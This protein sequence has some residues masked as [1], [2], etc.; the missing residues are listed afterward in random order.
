MRE[1]PG[2][3]S[4]PLQTRYRKYA[5]DGRDDAPGFNTPSKKIEIYSEVLL[6]HG[7]AAL[8]E[9][10]EPG[11]G[12]AGRPNLAEDFP[13]ILTSVKSPQYLGSQGRAFPA[14]RRIK[15]EPQI[16]LHPDAAEARGIQNG[17]WVAL[18]TPHGRLR[19]K[20][21]YSAKLHPKVVVA[22]HG[23]WQANTTLSL[24]GYDVT[25]GEGANLNAAIANE[26]IDPISGAAPHKC[27][28]CQ[29][30]ALDEP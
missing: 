25:G 2:G 20:A 17:E 26:T 10:V 19:V 21:L 15:P 24:P 3:I 16:E 6:R 22:T 27:Y 23:W 13:L 4:V 12:A 29:I 7:Y 28:A 5:G 9:F 14:L 8:P 1:N 11:M 30:V 18:L